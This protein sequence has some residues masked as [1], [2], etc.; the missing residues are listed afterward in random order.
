MSV[1]ENF[2]ERKGENQQLMPTAFHP[3]RILSD[4]L[5]HFGYLSPQ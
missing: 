1:L 4:N 2:M 5:P 3:I